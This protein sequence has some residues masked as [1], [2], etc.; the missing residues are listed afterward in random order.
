MHVASILRVNMVV[1]ALALLLL[2]IPST[3]H[4]VTVTESGDA[5][6]L[7]SSAQSS[8]GVPTLI[9]G[10]LENSGDEDVYRVCLTGDGTFSAS[11]VGSALVDPQLFLFDA[12][13]RGVYANDD[14]VGLQS[15][16]PAGNPLTP[17]AAGTYYLAIT[18]FNNDPLSS[19]G[20]IF[21]FGFPIQ[22]PDG[23]GG[24][25][26]VTGWTDEGFASGA[27]QITLTGTQA[28]LPVTKEEC[29]SGGWRN[30]G[31]FRNQGDCVSFVA[32]G[33]KNPPAGP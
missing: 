33:G 17:T 2:A 19:G 24:G 5:G 26:P 1:G 31:V 23:P 25:S 14:F 21:G 9:T 15:T 12:S 30:F 13:G 11:T 22:G 18:S 27:Y 4:G 29:R 3:A 16:L 32:T 20:P 28:C 10:V 7:P 8:T 6:S